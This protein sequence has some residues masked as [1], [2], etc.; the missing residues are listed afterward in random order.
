MCRDDRQM[1][2][3]I[4]I[5]PALTGVAAV[6][7]AST[8]AAPSSAAVVTLTVV[9]VAVAAVLVTVAAASVAKIPSAVAYAPAAAEEVGL[10]LA[11]KKASPPAALV[12]S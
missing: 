2:R 3:A 8:D 5:G 1:G 12:A 7:P 9:S 11:K 10:V 4:C 6:A